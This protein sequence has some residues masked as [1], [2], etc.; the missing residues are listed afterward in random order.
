MGKVNAKRMIKRMKRQ[1][2]EYKQV[3]D[4]CVL[5]AGQ[6][7]V[8]I[9]LPYE[10]P[11]I[12]ENLLRSQQQGSPA[13]HQAA[14]AKASESYNRLAAMTHQ[15]P[16]Q[17][18]PP[19]AHH[20]APV[21]P[22]PNP[23]DVAAEQAPMPPPPPVDPWASATSDAAI[24]D[25]FE[26]DEPMFDAPDNGGSQNHDIASMQAAFEAKQA[27]MLD[28]VSN[29]G[30]QYKNSPG[31]A[32]GTRPAPHSNAPQAP[33]QASGHNQAPPPGPTSSTAPGPAPAP[34][35]N[36][37]LKGGMTR[38]QALDMIERATGRRPGNPPANP[39][40]KMD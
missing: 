20:Q 36:R 34:P 31:P 28:R 38:G 21:A 8:V 10:L 11:T 2:E 37:R 16:H 15:P 17:A 23:W 18:S 40:I 1:S 35:D 27:Q 29:T 26:E 4:A 13:D 30:I 33:P 22:Q 6:Y 9:N 3:V 12:L 7:G 5:I 14:Q 19:Q 24:D 39:N 25:V 32:A